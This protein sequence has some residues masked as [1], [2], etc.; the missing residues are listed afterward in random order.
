MT[1]STHGILDWWTIAYVSLCASSLYA[2]SIQINEFL[3]ATSRTDPYGTSLEWIEIVNTGLDPVSLSDYSL[4]DDPLSPRKWILPDVILQPGGYILIWATGYNRYDRDDYHTNFRLSR[5]GEYLAIYDAGFNPVDAIEYPIQRQDI[6]YGRH[7]ADPALWFFLLNP[8]PNAE[9]SGEAIA[10]LPKPRYSL[11]AGFYEQPID[12][13]LETGV[14]GAIVRY[15]TDGS[16]PTITSSIYRDPI[17]LDKTTP[18]RSRVFLSDRVYGGIS[19]QTYV[20]NQPAPLPVLSLSTHPSN[21]WDRSTGIYT[22]AT[23][24]GFAWERPVTFEWISNTG[25][26]SVSIDAGLR[27]HG[28]ASRTRS[29]KKSFRVYFRSDYGPGRLNASIIPSTKIDSFDSLVLRAGY[30]DSWVHWDQIERDVAVY[31]SDQLGRDTH[32]DMGF[33]SSHGT[34]VNLYLNGEYWGIYNVCERIEGDFLASYFGYDDWDIVSDE[35]LKEGDWNAWNE[36]R[37]FVNR[38]DFTDPD[39]FD[40]I[41]RFVDLD[42]ITA[43]YI[44]NIWVQN[45]DWPHHN[46]FAGRERSSL[47]RWKFFVW[48]IEDSFGSGASRGAYNLNTFQ[49]AKEGTLIGTLF[50]KLTQNPRYKLYFVDQLETYLEYPLNEAHLLNRLQEQLN[51]IRGAIPME[52][53]RWNRNKSLADW[54]AAADIARRFIRNRTSYV[55]THVYRGLQLPTPTAT[56]ISTRPSPSPTPGGNAMTPTPTATPTSTPTV[57]PT[58]SSQS[59]GLFTTHQDI[60]AVSAAGSAMYDP[61]TGEY[62]VIGSG[63]D[64]WGTSDAFHFLY[65]PIQGPFVFE[66]VMTAQNEGSS[67]W[68]KAALMARETLEPDSKNFAVRVRESIN[69]LSSQWRPRQGGESY[70]TTAQQRVDAQR[71]ANRVRLV[72][73]QNTFEAYYYDILQNQWRLIDSLIIEMNETVLIGLA[74]TSHDDGRYA[75]GIFA[76][77]SIEPLE[78]SLPDWFLY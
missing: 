52:A 54:E 62:T 9:N 40:S 71:H 36:L 16:E 48:D 8:T 14:S 44:L 27:I 56:P 25:Q 3:A 2:N 13:A 5:S 59:M 12:V 61:H 15:T 64:M 30:N 70:S 37:D 67:D 1:R 21:L 38:T 42:E 11:P 43:Y 17:G 45:H 24:H 49:K 74:V 32:R 23:Q 39:V 68:A 46:W 65:R 31:V 26:P 47:G 19:T 57:T 60:G 66:A 10:D 63:A 50:A 28:G 18:L 55:Q 58:V 29:E 34:Y 78:V 75:R 41:Q 6:S 51:Q 69:Q 73:D 22:N 53:E 77:V 4:T 7:S 72:R 35:E 20:I 33:V 76:E